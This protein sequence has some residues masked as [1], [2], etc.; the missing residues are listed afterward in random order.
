MSQL[1][2]NSIIEFIVEFFSELPQPVVAFIF[3]LGVFAMIVWAGGIIILIL[4]FFAIFITQY[5]I[6]IIGNCVLIFLALCIYAL[7]KAVHSYKST[8]LRYENK[9][10]AFTS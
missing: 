3:S 10:T 2:I 6:V 4:G 8:M 7:I 5:G 1:N 9:E